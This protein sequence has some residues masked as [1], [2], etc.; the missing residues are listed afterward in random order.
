MISNDVET[1]SPVGESGGA[2]SL[3]PK[4]VDGRKVARLARL[5]WIHEYIEGS[6]KPVLLYDLQSIVSRRFEISARQ[7][8]DDIMSFRK[9]S[10]TFHFWK[11]R[12][13]ELV[14]T[15]QRRY[16]RAV[17]PRDGRLET[18]DA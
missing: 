11:V 7:V 16:E 12:D 2:D 18:Y 1:V 5:V 10:E 3:P 6:F 8:R 4:K 15:H 9:R 17:R 13:R 14:W